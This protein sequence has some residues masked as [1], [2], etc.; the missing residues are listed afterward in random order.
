MRAID[1]RIP[2]AAPDQGSDLY[3]GYEF[4]K[5]V[6]A[7]GMVFPM[8]RKSV[9]QVFTA[10]AAFGG[11][12]L[13]G[14]CLSKADLEDLT[15][16]STPTVALALRWLLDAGHIERRFVSGSASRYRVPR[17]IQHTVGQEDGE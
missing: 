16:L 4:D 2:K 1:G 7:W 10:I 5:A 15:G 17:M 9:R 8:R 11:N 6:I 14:A 13:E 12:R 3:S